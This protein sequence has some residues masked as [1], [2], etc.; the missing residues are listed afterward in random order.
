MADRQTTPREWAL[1]AGG[2][3]ALAAAMI[4]WWRGPAAPDAPAVVLTMP[5]PAPL[6]PGP[7]EPP[8]APSADMSGLVLRGVLLRGDGGSAIIESADGRQ[9]LV[10]RGAMVVPGVR[11][12]ALSAGSVRLVSGDAERQLLLVPGQGDDDG[13]ASGAQ[14]QATPQSLV[15]TVSEYRLAL[16]ARR[17][18]GKITGWLVRDASRVP[19]LRLAGLQPGDVLLS[20][21]DQPLFSEEKIM[22]LPGEVAG[23]YSI[24]LDFEREGQPRSAQI[25]LKR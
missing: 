18:Q 20:V 2:G 11:L 4:W 19:L 8:P 24:S 3:L 12:E 22:D 16:T 25:D 17:D 10:R 21:N 6:P 23:A 15:A 1:A 7:V 14:R 9:R 13:A 5:P